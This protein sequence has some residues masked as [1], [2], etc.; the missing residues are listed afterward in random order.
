VPLATRIREGDRAAERE[1]VEL[2]EKRV[3]AIILARLLDPVLAEDLTQETL[4]AAL[5]ALRA[6]KLLA[7]EKLPA[8]L[9]GTA[10]N[11]CNNHLRG[12]GRQPL[13]AEV[14]PTSPRP[15]PESRL[16]RR[17]LLALVGRCLAEL[18]KTDQQILLWSLVDRLSSDEIGRRLGMRPDTVRQHKH[19]ALQKLRA[20]SQSL[21]QNPGGDHKVTGGEP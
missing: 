13:T 21:S 5:E 4:L 10:R 15:D 7:A 6:G 16:R 19:R 20:R 9:R 1:L 12:Q 11:L 2:Y 18:D 17:E 8:F 3:Y 14:D